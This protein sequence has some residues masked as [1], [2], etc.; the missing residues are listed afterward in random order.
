MMAILT[1]LQLVLPLLSGV[2]SMLTTSKAPVEV[3]ASVQKAIEEL[4]KVHG[5]VVTKVQV[6]SLLDTKTW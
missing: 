5:T 4:K 1:I 2:L 3:I 6:D